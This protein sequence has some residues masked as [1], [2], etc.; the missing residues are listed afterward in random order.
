LSVIET[1]QDTP[2][3]ATHS[4]SFDRRMQ[5]QQPVNCQQDDV[6]FPQQCGRCLT[7]VFAVWLLFA[8]FPAI[9]S[10]SRNPYIVMFDETA[11]R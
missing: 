5:C 10:G 8:R 11:G 2:S 3:P 4:I 9:E 1:C 6:V 7:E